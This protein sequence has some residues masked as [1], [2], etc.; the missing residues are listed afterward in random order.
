MHKLLVVV[1]LFFCQVGLSQIVN[2]KAPTI[3]DTP[4]LDKT[5]YKGK[6]KEVKHYIYNSL[7]VDDF[8]ITKELRRKRSKLEAIRNYDEE[9]FLIMTKFYGTFSRGKKKGFDYVETTKFSHYPNGKIKQCRIDKK[10]KLWTDVTKI[11]YRYDTLDRLEKIDTI[12]MIDDYVE[13][14][15]STN[16]KYKQ[17]EIYILDKN[18]QLEKIEYLDTL[19]RVI[20][21]VYY[22]NGDSTYYKLYNYIYDESKD[23][24]KR[25]TTEYS[26]RY[27]SGINIYGENGQ[28]VKKLH[29]DGTDSRNT[30]RPNKP[31]EYEIKTIESEEIIYTYKV[32]KETGKK[33]LYSKIIRVKDKHKNLIKWYNFYNIGTYSESLNLI[34]Y[35][36]TYWD[37]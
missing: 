22:T 36:I 19:N 15:K 16:Y 34:E 24:I 23:K 11:Y 28:F 1:F 2:T 31:H 10:W 12:K 25:V 35:E 3:A 13:E 6:V 32:D 17:R 21:S 26:M 37:D 8:K 18:Q 29:L 27:G 20:K 7:P 14:V 9:G 5:V 33:N 4:T 30:F